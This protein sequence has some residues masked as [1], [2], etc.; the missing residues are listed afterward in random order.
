MLAMN[1]RAILIVVLALMA[2][3]ASRADDPP[4]RFALRGVHVVEVGQGTLLRDA[5]VVVEG[6]RISR[7][8]TGASAREL[9][10]G[11][12]I[13]D[14]TGK[15][16]IPG[17]WD[18]HVHSYIHERDP[19]WIFPLLVAHGVTGIRD[20]GSLVP[21]ARMQAIRAEIARGDRIGPRV[22]IAGPILDG[23]NTVW[24]DESGVPD[25]DEARQAVRALARQGADFIKVYSLLSPLAYRTVIEEARA[26]GLPVSGQVPE[27]ITIDDA[28]RAGQR[29]IEHIEKLLVGCSRLE[30][31]VVER[32]RQALEAVA[33]TSDR[34]ELLV[35]DTAETRRV[36]AALDGARC[37]RMAAA[38]ARSQVAVVPTLVDFQLYAAAGAPVADPRLAYIPSTIREAWRTMNAQIALAPADQVALAIQVGRAGTGLVRTLHGNGVRILAGTHVAPITPF[39]FPGSA[40]HDELIAL[41]AAGLS[42]LE[43]LQAATIGPARHFGDERNAG[44]VAAGRYADLV[45]LD[46]DPI[47]D[48]ANVRRIHAVVADGRL[49]ERAALDGLLSA[50]GAMAR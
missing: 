36:L 44:S 20:M 22:R 42:N 19:D 7:V 46:A 35:A 5:T 24:R 31:E 21:I 11:L 48:V 25:P 6:R 23:L 34:L 27:T 26:L 41:R 3:G 12:R 45:V 2:A 32:H 14:A 9:P 17:L 1:L 13:V 50:V 8:L 30:P 33:T 40:L 18:M 47:A 10:R 49:F 43:A 15:F 29:S 28:I 37:S 4:N 16:V 39:V 38:L